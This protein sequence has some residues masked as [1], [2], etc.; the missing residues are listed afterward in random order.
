M[1]LANK[2]VKIAIV[3]YT[4]GLSGGSGSRESP[5]NAG[6]SGLI[7]GWEWSPGEGNSNPLQ[8]FCLGNHTDRGAW[9][10]TVHGVATES[11]TTK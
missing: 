1:E 2:S 3:N 4:G 11:D 6:H 8:N 5:A 10:A 7:P 9:W